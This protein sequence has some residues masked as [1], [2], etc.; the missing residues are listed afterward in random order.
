MLVSLALNSMLHSE[1]W[2]TQ[3]NSTSQH[4][5]L[6][7]ARFSTDVSRTRMN[8]IGIMVNSGTCS[9]VFCGKPLVELVVVYVKSTMTAFPSSSIPNVWMKSRVVVAATAWASI[10]ASSGPGQDAHNETDHD[11]VHDDYKIYSIPT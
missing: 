1:I 9:V 6:P 8:G 11:N 5:N 3:R 7:L 10:T 4:H 2:R